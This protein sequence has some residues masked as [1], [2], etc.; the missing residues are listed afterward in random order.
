MAA[1]MYSFTD[2]GGNPVSL[3]PEFTSSIVRWF[4]G[5]DQL[6]V[7]PLRAQYSGP[8]F[9]YRGDYEEHRQFH[10]AGV[11]LIGSGTPKPTPRCSSWP[12]RVW[13]PLGLTMFDW[14]LGTWAYTKT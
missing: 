1:Q 7:L 2:P 11:E 9:R 14:F 5:E 13:Q 10:Q 8:V 12:A 6:D 3:R 4:L